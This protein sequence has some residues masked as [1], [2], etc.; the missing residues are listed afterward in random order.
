M[1]K[2]T[3]KKEVEVFQLRA[4]MNVRYWEDAIVNGIECRSAE[5]MPLA[6]DETWSIFVWIDNGQIEGWPSGVTADVHFKVCDGGLYELVDEMGNTIV[7]ID[8]YVPDIMCPEGGGYGDYVIMKI[9]KDGIIQNWKVV[10]DEFIDAL[11]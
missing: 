8:G 10:L 2:I 6:E 3:V 9:N 7:E 1:T 11:D 4:E 5:D